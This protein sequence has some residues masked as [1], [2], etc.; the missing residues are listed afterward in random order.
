MLGSYPMRA[1]SV[2]HGAVAVEGRIVEWVQMNVMSRTGERVGMLREDAG[3]R[4]MRRERTLE[5]DGARRV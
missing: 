2:C 3:G 1:V 4:R 5:S